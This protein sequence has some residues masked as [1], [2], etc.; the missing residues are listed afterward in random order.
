MIAFPDGS[1]KAVS[2]FEVQS[3]AAPTLDF[4]Y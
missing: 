1:H 2:N 4:K 3:G